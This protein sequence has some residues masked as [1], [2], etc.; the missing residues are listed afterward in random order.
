MGYFSVLKY[1]HQSFKLQDNCEIAYKYILKELEN[2]SNCFDMEVLNKY[3]ENPDFVELCILCQILSYVDT[4]EKIEYIS[5]QFKDFQIRKQSDAIITE[6]EIFTSSIMSFIY[7][8]F[9]IMIF[10]DNSII[11]ENCFKNIIVSLDLQGRHLKFGTYDIE[12]FLKILKLPDN[13][14]HIA[15]DIYY[16][17]WAFQVAH[18]IY[19]IICN[20]EDNSITQEIE[21][22]KYGYSVLIKLIEEQKHNKI[23][24][25]CSCFYE[26][27]YLSPIILFEYYK[28]YDFWRELCGIKVENDNMHPSNQQREDMIFSLFDEV[29][30]DDLNTEE[31]NAI[32]TSFLD[33]LDYVIENIKIKASCGKLDSIIKRSEI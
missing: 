21:A 2:G 19:H 11:F 20:E 27:T 26:Y 24:K 31:G 6:D 22:D 29:V 10:P 3:K 8:I 17:I 18:E 23:T 9:A 16:S 14:M 25:D 13:I 5:C 28:L 7:S 30:P 12:K 33:T 15:S 32:I 1:F 4:K